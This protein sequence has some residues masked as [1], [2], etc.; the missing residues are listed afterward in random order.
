MKKIFKIFKIFTEI[1]TFL[2]KVCYLLFIQFVFPRKI[3]YFTGGWDTLHP[4]AAY[5]YGG[6]PRKKF[7]VLYRKKKKGIEISRDDYTCAE[8]GSLTPSQVEI[9]LKFKR[10]KQ[11]YKYF[12]FKKPNG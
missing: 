12:S 2:F 7:L 10:Q 6:V 11:T 3:L 1:G 5:S 9:N 4:F 8:Y